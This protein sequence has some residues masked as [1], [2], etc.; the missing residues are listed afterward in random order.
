MAEILNDSNQG[1]DYYANGQCA[2]GDNEGI[3]QTFYQPRPAVVN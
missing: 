3:S 2:D 1:A